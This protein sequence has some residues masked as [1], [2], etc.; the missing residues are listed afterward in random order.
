MHCDKWLTCAKSLGSRE[1]SLGGIVALRRGRRRQ[2]KKLYA[3]GYL[4]SPQQGGFK[5]HTVL[6]VCNVIGAAGLLSLI[7]YGFFSDRLQNLAQS[8]TGSRAIADVEI[9]VETTRRLNGPSAAGGAMGGVAVASLGPRLRGTGLE[10]SAGNGPVVTGSLAPANVAG[11]VSTPSDAVRLRETLVDDFGAAGLDQVD[12]AIGGDVRR[13]IIGSGKASDADVH[14]TPVRLA[15]LGSIGDVLPTQATGAMEADSLSFGSLFREPESRVRGRGYDAIPAPT[16]VPL[17]RRGDTG[18]ELMMSFA[19]PPFQV[20]DVKA[21]TRSD[22]V[23]AEEAARRSIEEKEPTRDRRLARERY[24]LAAAI[25]YEARGEPRNG[26][27][28]VAQVVL[29]RV[30]DG[31]YPGTV[32]GVVF[33][34]ENRKHRCQFSFACDGKPERPKP[35]AAWTQSLDIAREFLNGFIY[36]PVAA[37]THYHADYVSPRWSRSSEMT[38]VRQIGNHIFYT[39]S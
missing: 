25:Y 18:A 4:Q 14:E 9:S 6:A 30:E 39:E 3:A 19:A 24:C 15:S 34:D 21:E 37:A 20:R 13:V 23:R 35:G 16:R 5:R 36:Q 28:A 2:S 11:R 29:N 22:L 7:S 27:Q 12:I 38:R 8:D 31:R 1:D 32:C 33:Q 17:V 26:Q 10:V